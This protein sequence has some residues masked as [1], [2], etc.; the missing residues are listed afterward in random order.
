[1]AVTAVEEPVS[2]EQKFSGLG[3]GLGT[4]L[5]ISAWLEGKLS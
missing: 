3:G 4:V 1:M 2:G 5:V